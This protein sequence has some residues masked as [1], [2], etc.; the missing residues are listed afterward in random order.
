MLLVRPD[1]IRAS[2]RKFVAIEHTSELTRGYSLFDDRPERNEPNATVIDDVDADGFYRAYLE[3]LS[4][5]N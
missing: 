2:S 1:L 5:R 4:G 3:L